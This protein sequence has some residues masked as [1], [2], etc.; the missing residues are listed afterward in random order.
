[1]SRQL[2]LFEGDRAT[3]KQ[4]IELTAQSLNAYGQDYDHWAISFSGGKDSSA[5]VTLTAHLIEMGAVKPPKT[6]TVLYADTRQELPPL[7]QSAMQILERCRE[8]GWQ[9]EICTAEMDK[10]FWVY[11]LGRG[12]PPPNNSTMRW[13]TEQIKLIPMKQ[14][15]IRR[16]EALP[17]NAKYK[18]LKALAK[19]VK[20]EFEKRHGRGSAKV[21][22]KLL[23][24]QT[25]RK[26]EEVF[27]KQERILS[28]NGVRIGESAMR[29]RRIA[30]SCS[31]NGSE[32]GQGWFQRD[33]PD[34]ICDKLSPI[35]HWR[36]CLIWD[37]LIQA[38]IELG[39]STYLLSQVYGGEEA[40]ELNA[41]TGCIG[42]P[43]ASEDMA[44]N[45]LV[46]R[47]EYEYLAPLQEIRWW[48]SEARKFENR[49]QKFGERNQDGNF[50]KNPCRKGPLILEFREKMLAAILRIQATCNAQCPDGA[51]PV[52]IINPHEE[53]RIRELID[54]KT[55]PNKWTGNEPRGDVL[56]DT[57]YSNG[58]V[59]PVLF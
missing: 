37:W 47:P 8:L 36:V 7:Q 32:C 19:F 1:M 23:F 12:V 33:L 17:G 28:L 35:L 56:L 41:R 38:A 6:M 22:E 3:E 46:K 16:Y 31:K 15:L 54:A 27:G 34:L 4:A 14:A 30:L 29:D 59:Q 42:C 53:T 40:T 50:S 55:F 45:A 52:D 10:R 58:S 24:E 48:H 44:L 57:I 43:L 18:D 26:I 49:L 39:F 20:R 2:T 11:L 51:P 9:T 13:C 21:Q 5:L 25:H